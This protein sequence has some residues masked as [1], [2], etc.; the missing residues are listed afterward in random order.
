M[1][2]SSVFNIIS[3]ILTTLFY[4][5]ILKPTLTYDIMNDPEEY[6][7]YNKAYYNSLSI[8]LLLVIIIQF[9]VNVIMVAGKCGGSI[10]S[11]IA[12]AG[13]YT[14]FPWILIFGVMMIVIIVYPGFK[15]AFSDVIGYYYVAGGANKVL[16]DLLIDK[17]VQQQIDESSGSL[18]QKEDLENVADAIIKITGNTSI[19][20]NQIVPD[21]FIN[22]WNLLNPLMKLKYQTNTPETIEKRDS[23]F[24][25]V[26]TRD[27]VGES[28]WFLYTGIL[29]SSIVQM[30]IS[31]TPCYVSPKQMEQNYQKF[32]DQENKAQEQK[33][34]AQSTVYTI[35]N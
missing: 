30:K 29:L 2:S 6:A 22:F 1:A 33:A 21:N 7:S 35:K 20:I 10:Q 19:L 27:N 24:S 16:S 3:F 17:N 18:K 14:L 25:L 11:N 8:Y 5:L 28:M 9:I 13:L 26:V 34:T 12:A 15:T 31:T 32:L 4:Y 23:L